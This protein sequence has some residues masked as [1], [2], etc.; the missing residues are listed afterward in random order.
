MNNN[1]NNSITTTMKTRLLL[2]LLC[3]ILSFSGIVTA[4]EVSSRIVGGN[5][6][7]L[8]SKYSFFVSIQRKGNRGSK[9]SLVHHCGGTLIASDIYSLDCCT[10]YEGYNCQKYK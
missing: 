5:K 1:T 8:P 3:L 6:I 2:I 4:I 7:L 9:S 10:L